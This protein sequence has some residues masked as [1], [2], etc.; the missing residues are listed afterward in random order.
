[1]SECFYM[2]VCLCLYIWQ[3]AKIGNK[4]SGLMYFPFTCFAYKK[5][6][7]AQDAQNNIITIIY[8]CLKS[9]A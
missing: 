4:V 5:M 8:H 7:G 2:C 3:L 1:M 9:I 6:Y